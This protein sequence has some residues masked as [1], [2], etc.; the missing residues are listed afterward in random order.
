MTAL[1]PSPPA[2]EQLAFRFPERLEA[3]FLKFHEDN[4]A[5]YRFL[6][7]RVRQWKAGGH[8]RGSIRMFWELARFEFCQTVNSDSKFRLNN[9][10][11]AFYSR[12]IMQQEP[13]LAGFF[14]TREGHE[15]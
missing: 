3:A 12:L 5:V 2:I 4:P 9:N 14:E 15:S 11:H 10:H 7:D 6:V 1:P 8:A 13:D